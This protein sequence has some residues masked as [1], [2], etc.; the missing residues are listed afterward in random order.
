MKRTFNRAGMTARGPADRGYRRLSA[1][2]P[3]P[4]A[5]PPT[6][7]SPAAASGAWSTR[8]TSCPASSRS[9]RATPAAPSE[10]DL[11]GG[12]GGRSPATPSRSTWSTTR[13][14]SPTRSCSTSS[15]TTSIRSRGTPVLRPRARST[16]RRIFV[17]DEDAEAARRGFEGRGAEAAS[18]SRSSPRSRR[19]RAFWPAEGYHQDYYKKN[20]VRYKFY[21]SSCGRDQRLEEIW[22]KSGE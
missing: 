8:S 16:A 7:P 17:H 1:R 4:P 12:L 5:R 11:R 19:R 2:R 15:G 10:P 21:R 9:P 18:S 3:P 14:R 13:R 6:R 20:P 22:G